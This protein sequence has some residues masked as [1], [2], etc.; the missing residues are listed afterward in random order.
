MRKFPE[1]GAVRFG[2]ILLLLSGIRCGIKT[3]YNQTRVSDLFNFMKFDNSV[4][5]VLLS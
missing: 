1:N 5:S 3:M 4:K 2:E